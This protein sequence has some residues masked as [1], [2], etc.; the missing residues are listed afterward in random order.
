MTESTQE[1]RSFRLPKPLVY[2]VKALNALSPYITHRFLLKFFFTPLKFPTPARE[3]FFKQTCDLRREKINNKSITIYHKGKSGPNLLFCHGWSGRSTQFADLAS[4]LI[5]NGFR[6]TLFT[7]PAHGSSEDKETDL[8]EFIETIHFC[9]KN[10]GPFEAAI[11]HSLGGIAV[12]NACKEGLHI[13][14]L[15][16]I[17]SPATVSGVVDDFLNVVGAGSKTRRRFIKALEK[18]YQ[19]QLDAAAP[20]LL[21]QNESIP[22]LIVHDADD[23]DATVAYAYQLEKV[24]RGSELF[25]TKGLGHRKILSDPAVMA[26]IANFLKKDT[27]L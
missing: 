27:T 17:G 9:E 26:A 3:M 24:W 2:S 1:T 16:T 6:V 13:N 10:F 7:A 22:G 5:E 11:G 25:I 8:R 19:Q 23:L 20:L 15:V 21:M 18:R 4:H 12:I 14:K